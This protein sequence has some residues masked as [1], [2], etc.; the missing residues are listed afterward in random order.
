MDVWRVEVYIYGD[1]ETQTHSPDCNGILFCGG[2]GN[3][4]KR[5]LSSFAITKKI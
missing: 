4:R 5:Y 1:L 2:D 3:S